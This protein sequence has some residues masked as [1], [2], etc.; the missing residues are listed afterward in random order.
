[1]VQHGSAL[2]NILNVMTRKEHGALL[3]KLECGSKG[4]CIYLWV[5]YL[6]GDNFVIRQLLMWSDGTK[7]PKGHLTHISFKLLDDIF[8][9]FLVINAMF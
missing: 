1:M 8:L 3:C 4:I 2:W 7:G 5:H 6:W 9:S